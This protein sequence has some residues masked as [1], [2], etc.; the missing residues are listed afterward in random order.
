MHAVPS[1]PVPLEVALADQQHRFYA[2]AGP[3]AFAGTVPFRLSTSR[4]MA[5]LVVH[6]AAAFAQAQGKARVRLV[7]VGAGSGR[8]GYH[9]RALRPD[10]SL[11]LTDASASMCQALAAHPQLHGAAVHHRPAT[12]LGPALACAPDEALVVVGTYLLDT[13]P[14]ALVQAPDGARAF[15]DATGALSFR[16]APGDAFTRAYLRR[17]GEGRAFLPVGAFDLVRALERRLDGPALLLLADKMA[18]TL[19]AAREGE[20]PRLVRHGA[21]A[22]V[23]VNFDALRAWLGWR[24]VAVAPGGTDDFVV[25]STVLKGRVPVPGMF[26]GVPHPLAVQARVTALRVPATPVAGGEVVGRGAPVAGDGA[27]ERGALPEAGDAALRGTP[28]AASTSVGTAAPPVVAGVLALEPDGDALL[29]L[30]DVLVAHAPHVTGE[31]RERLGAWLLSAAQTAFV[32]PADDVAFHAGRVLQAL[33][34]AGAAVAC[35]SESLRRHGD[36]PVTRLFRASSL[37][38]LD[39]TG[40]AREDVAAVL[41]VDPA[42]AQALALWASLEAGE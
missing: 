20:R 32:L 21:G 11:V 10:L 33:S 30:S 42:H 17:L 35:F 9:V 40:P 7:D 18:T 6:A 29:E 28:A 36:A 38:A 19:S 16:Q 37:L 26:D 3:G 23:L 2:E 22:S 24:G 27:A 31:A 25:A 34:F 41:A 13:L 4:A 39:A 8:L 15:V 14:H 12:D 5:R 1:A